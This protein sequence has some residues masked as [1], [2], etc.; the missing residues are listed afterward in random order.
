VNLAPE[1]D[2][3]FVYAPEA[4]ATA[5]TGAVVEQFDIVNIL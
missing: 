3:E 5:A 4:Y 2:P 1:H